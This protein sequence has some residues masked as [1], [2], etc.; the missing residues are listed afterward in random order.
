M[1]LLTI[2]DSESETKE[3]TG[4]RTSVKVEEAACRPLLHSSSS[5]LMDTEYKNHF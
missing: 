2:N 1:M 5:E 3:C 4:S